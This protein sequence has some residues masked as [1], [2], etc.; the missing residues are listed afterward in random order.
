MRQFSKA[1]CPI[2][3]TE[4][5]I[6]ISFNDVQ[7]LNVFHLISVTD[8]EIITSLSDVHPSKHSPPIILTDSGISI[9]IN[10]LHPLNAIKE[11]SQQFAN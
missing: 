6:T 11:V 3:V 9:L 2:I 4:F 8:D 1:R 7:S 10:R 5:G